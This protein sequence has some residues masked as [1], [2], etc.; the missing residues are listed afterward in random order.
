MQNCELFIFLICL[1]I[2]CLA[3]IR[4]FDLFHHV[5]PPSKLERFSITTTI[6]KQKGIVKVARKKESSFLSV[7][8]TQFCILAHGIRHFFSNIY[9]IF[10]SWFCIRS[11]E[12]WM[13]IYL[14]NF[15][16]ITFLFRVHSRLYIFNFIIHTLLLSDGLVISICVR[17]LVCLCVWMR[18]SPAFLFSRELVTQSRVLWCV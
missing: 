7:S 15:E 10:F 5:F 8:R 18:T 9:I 12:N 3:S 4:V 2:N 13:K 16:L 1:A 11:D 6:R 17:T 14:K